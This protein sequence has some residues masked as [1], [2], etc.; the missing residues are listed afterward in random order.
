MGAIGAGDRVLGREIER[1]L[2]QIDRVAIVRRVGLGPAQRVGNAQQ[3]RAAVVV[4]EVDEQ[5][6]IPRFRRRLPAVDA[7]VT[8]ERSRLIDHAKSGPHPAAAAG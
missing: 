2:R 6:V 1:I 3:T 5:S 4:A 8:Q 7:R